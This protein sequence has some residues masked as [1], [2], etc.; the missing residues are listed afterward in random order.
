MNFA[1]KKARSCGLAIEARTVGS[2]KPQDLQ[3]RAANRPSL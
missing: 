3:R 2:E 1:A